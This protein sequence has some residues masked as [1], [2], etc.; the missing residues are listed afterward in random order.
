MPVCN[1]VVCFDRPDNLKSF[2]Q[3]RGRA[4]MRSSKLYL[5]FDEDPRICC[6]AGAVWKKR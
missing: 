2:I 6:R 3:R 4:R 5:L 1:L